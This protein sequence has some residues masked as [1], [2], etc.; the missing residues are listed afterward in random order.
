MTEAATAVAGPA[1]GP[2]EPAAPG[3]GRRVRA[4]QTG[5]QVL[6]AVPPVPRRAKGE[7]QHQRPAPSDPCWA[8]GQGQHRWTS[9]PRRTTAEQYLQDTT[10]A[11]A[12]PP[13]QWEIGRRD[14]GRR[15]KDVGRWWSKGRRTRQT[16][17]GER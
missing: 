9:S 5:Q 16:P 17:R 12:G 3:A 2:G 1:A 11:V 14:Q 7:K 8:Q 4:A 15:W 13:G 6:R 10:V